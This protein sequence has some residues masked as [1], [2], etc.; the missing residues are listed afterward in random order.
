MMNKNLW[1]ELNNWKNNCEW[2]ELS[3]E[4]S[5]N[6]PHWDGFPDMSMKTIFDFDTTI[7]Q[8][9]EHTIVSQYGTHVDA[10]VHFV[11]GASGLDIFTPKDLIMPLCVID[12][13][14]IAAEN[15]D[16]SLTK[17]DIL[18]W[19]DKYG[20]IPENAFVAFRT[21]WYKKDTSE[22]MDNKDD[23]GNK[24]Y[25]GWGIDALKFLVEER[26]IG[27][28]G[29][30]QSDTDAPVVSSVDGYVGEYY[31]LNQGRFQIEL[32]KNLDKCSPVGGLIFT[33]FPKVKNGSGF[34]ARCFAVCPK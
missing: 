30:E 22:K 15:A 26:N 4:V 11:K 14:E 27:A 31:I 5:P 8:V 18:D 17:Q 23:A 7:F 19:E 10:P 9:Y 12:K 20:K 33:T 1:E 34:T 25:P 21:D 13:S 32:L 28:I 3:H 29:H 2:I 24:H 16:Y 6:T